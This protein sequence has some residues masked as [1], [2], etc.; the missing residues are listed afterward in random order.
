DYFFGRGDVAGTTSRFITHLFDCSLFPPQTARMNFYLPCFIAFI[1]HCANLHESV[2]FVALQLILRLRQRFPTDKGISGHRLFIT[3]YMVSSK[4]LCDDCYP[5]KSWH[6]V[7]RGMYAVYEINKMERDFCRH[8]Q[9]DLSIDNNNITEL[10]TM[11]Y[12]DFSPT[13]P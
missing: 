9:W 13:S 3:A 4:L 6:E 1:M 7:S 5:N 12:R 8:L 2:L 11:L 10:R